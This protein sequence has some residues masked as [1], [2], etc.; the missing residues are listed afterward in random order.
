MKYGLPEKART[1]KKGE[2]S[3]GAAT[4]LRRRVGGNFYTVFLYGFF[5]RRFYTV[6]FTRRKIEFGY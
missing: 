5:T 1:V 6:T 3:F 4:V 2:K